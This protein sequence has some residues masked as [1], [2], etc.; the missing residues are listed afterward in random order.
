MTAQTAAA[1]V[2]H[3]YAWL[4][5]LDSGVPP[6]RQI[7]H[8]PRFALRA[9]LRDA[10]P[11]P[12]A[13]T[14]HLSLCFVT[15]EP[16]AGEPALAAYDDEAT[17]LI[18]AGEAVFRTEGD[19]EVARLRQHEGILAPK[20]VP[21]RYE[22]AGDGLLLLLRGAGRKDPVAG[23][24]RFYT[25]IRRGGP[26]STAWLREL[27]PGAAEHPEPFKRF[28]LRFPLRTA[29]DSPWRP[30]ARG[31]HISLHASSREPGLGEANLHSH[32]D[33]AAWVVLYGRATFWGEADAR[34]LC[35]LGP[36]DGI[37][38][39]KDAHYR[40]LNTGDGYLIMLRYGARGEP[41]SAGP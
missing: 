7:E 24:E 40:Y 41:V 19:R 35:T 5:P 18:L 33:E 27:W 31:E 23:Y 15:L 8:Y 22:N 28:T 38:I 12:L 3:P 6:E 32:D 14:R 21:Y 34:E 30:L 9:P 16:G 2:T 11:M 20:G 1:L 39:P 29:G 17:W 10:D 4:Q 36:H 25:G 37:V 26:E 13:R